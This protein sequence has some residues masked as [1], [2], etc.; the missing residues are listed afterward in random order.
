MEDILWGLWSNLLIIAESALI[1]D[2]VGQGFTML[3]F[4]VLQW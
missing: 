3:G 4:E 1:L 2:Q